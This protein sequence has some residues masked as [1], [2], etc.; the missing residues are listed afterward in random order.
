MTR[1]IGLTP[2]SWSK[3]TECCGDPAAQTHKA[4]AMKMASDKLKNAALSG[5]R[6]ICTACTHCQIQYTRVLD[7]TGLI[8]AQPF[9]LFLGKA[10]GLKGKLFNVKN[11]GNK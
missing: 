2:L 8:T 11:I 4:M 10:M 7:D 9:V 5:A 6:Y 3:E 1:I